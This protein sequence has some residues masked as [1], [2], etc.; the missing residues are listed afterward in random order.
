[1]YILNY[2]LAINIF[3]ISSN[4]TRFI[5]YT[6]GLDS[7]VSTVMVFLVMVYGGLCHRR[8]SPREISVFSCWQS[9]YLLFSEYMCGMNTEEWR[10]ERAWSRLGL[11]CKFFRS[12]WEMILSVEQHISLWFITLPCQTYTEELFL[13]PTPHLISIHYRSC[14]Q[15]NIQRQLHKMVFLFPCSNNYVL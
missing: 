8:L 7:R 15:W 6:I 11:S 14:W 3:T 12:L 9:T 2:S 5:H 10:E 4:I 13:P 1:M